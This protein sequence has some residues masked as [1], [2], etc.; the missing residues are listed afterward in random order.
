MDRLAAYQAYL[1]FLKGN[2]SPGR[3]ELTQDNERGGGWVGGWFGGWV[4]N[5][6]YDFQR[7]SLDGVKAG[8]WTNLKGLD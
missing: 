3:N 5:H 7:A 1:A 8:G 2:P 4:G 6:S